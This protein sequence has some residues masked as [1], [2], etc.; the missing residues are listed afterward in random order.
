ML[1]GDQGYEMGDVE[2]VDLVWGLLKCN[3]GITVDVS[4][5]F[6]PEEKDSCQ[7]CTDQYREQIRNDGEEHGE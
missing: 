1:Q 2:L 3:D 5:R 4:M 7:D 6:V